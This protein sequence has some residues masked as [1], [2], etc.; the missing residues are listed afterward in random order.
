MVLMD[1][2]Q[3]APKI[4]QLYI[5]CAGSRSFVFERLKANK[6][7]LKQIISSVL[8]LLCI[9]G[10]ITYIILKINIDFLIS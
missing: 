3:T 9:L 1:G 8:C 2:C 6:C 4:S 5:V 7:R 10:M